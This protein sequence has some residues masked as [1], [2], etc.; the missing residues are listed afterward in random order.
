MSNR[1]TLFQDRHNVN[2]DS[3]RSNGR[4]R[5]CRSDPKEMTLWTGRNA[6]IQR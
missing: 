3:K 5:L 1:R 2:S 6:W 4:A